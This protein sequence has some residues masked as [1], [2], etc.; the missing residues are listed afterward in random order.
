M[1]T[2]FTP[3][4]TLVIAKIA[5]GRWPNLQTLGLTHTRS[6]LHP[7]SDLV[8]QF[9]AFHCSLVS[10][11]WTFV[12]DPNGLNNPII[13]TLPINSL[14]FL[15]ALSTENSFLMSILTSPCTPVRPL[16][17]LLGM[18][19]GGDTWTFDSDIAKL[20]NIDKYTLKTVKIA[21]MESLNDLSRLAASFPNIEHLDLY[22]VKTEYDLWDIDTS[23]FRKPLKVWNFSLAERL[24]LTEMDLKAE[25]AMALSHFLNLRVVVGINFLPDNKPEDQEEQ[26]NRI[27]GLAALLPRLECFGHFISGGPIEI[28]RNEGKEVT[29]RKSDSHFVASFR[30]G[31]LLFLSS[32]SCLTDYISTSSFHTVKKCHT[33]LWAFKGL[34]AKGPV[35]T[36]NRD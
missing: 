16:K 1:I 24:E 12:P 25:W 7:N 32:P 35:G 11:E 10:L 4:S 31:M 8:A 36:A 21:G 28:L 2:T 22:S 14:P 26:E 18:K 29:W 6:A 27:R 30:L 23:S 33:S 17:R 9:L 13:L 15:E 34:F 5:N 3:L 20:L 19:L